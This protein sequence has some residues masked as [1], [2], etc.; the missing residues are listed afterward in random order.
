[1]GGGVVEDKTMMAYRLDTIELLI[2]P[3]VLPPLLLLFFRT[4]RPGAVI[5]EEVKS[6]Q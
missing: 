1:M 6:S 5:K 2:A 4:T 3:L